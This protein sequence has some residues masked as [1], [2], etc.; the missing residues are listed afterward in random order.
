MIELA[1]PA[2]WGVFVGLLNHLL[3][4]GPLQELS[5]LQSS[6]QP[7]D[8]K[9]TQRMMRRLY[10]RFGLRVVVSLVGIVIAYLWWGTPNALLAALI[11]LLLMNMGSLWQNQRMR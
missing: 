9:T 5:R 3:V 10:G 6:E 7:V 11:G 1:M 8:P 4:G 2:L